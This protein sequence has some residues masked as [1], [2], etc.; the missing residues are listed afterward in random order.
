MLRVF[1]VVKVTNAHHASYHKWPINQQNQSRK[2]KI[3]GVSS[4]KKYN[5]KIKFT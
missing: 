4:P 2:K 5:V 3:V 1:N